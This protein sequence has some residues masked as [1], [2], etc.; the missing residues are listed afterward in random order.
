MNPMPQTVDFI[1]LFDAL[2][3]GKMPNNDQLNE[4]LDR[5]LNIRAINERR[6]LMSSDGQKL[7]ADF[8]ALIV[9]LQKM[10]YTKNADHLFQ[11]LHYHLHNLNLQP[12]DTQRG[13]IKYINLHNA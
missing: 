1:D 13:N 6:N 10:L 8:Q 3:Q 4:I 12:S 2:R 9:T 5:M 11:S 7:L